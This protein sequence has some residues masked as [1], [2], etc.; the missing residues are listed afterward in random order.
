MALRTG[1][2]YLQGSI[3]LTL[4]NLWIAEN[5]E[6]GEEHLLRGQAIARQLDDREL[7]VD[8]NVALARLART[9]G[10]LRSAQA[11]L[12]QAT[13]QLPQT[14]DVLRLA[15]STWQ[16]WAE[17]A[18]AQNMRDGQVALLWAIAALYAEGNSSAAAAA[19]WEQ[20]ERAAARTETPE[21]RL[22]LAARARATLA[23][24]DGWGLLT[25]LFGR[26]DT[27]DQAKSNS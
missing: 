9:R 25:E 2:R 7:E 1:R 22:G 15:G 21:G 11:A 19:Y 23:E 3:E 10:D 4:A 12:R 8:V 27:D 14:G 18:E 24:D 5:P 16:E 17:L 13:T 20:A 6:V 26:F